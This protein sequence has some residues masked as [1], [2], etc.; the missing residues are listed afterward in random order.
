LRGSL[1]GL[2]NEAAASTTGSLVNDGNIRL[3]FNAGDG[4]SSLTVGGT[5]TNRGDLTIGN[6][7]LSAPDKVTAASLD[8]TYRIYLFGS[9]ANQAL[10]DV[11]GSAGDG[12]AGIP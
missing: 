12:V 6:P 3:D 7:S 5:L 4:G 8:N 2:H 11:T 1:P 9:G 10:L